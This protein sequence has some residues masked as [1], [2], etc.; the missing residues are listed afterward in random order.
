MDY[1][2]TNIAW[3]FFEKKITTISGVINYVEALKENYYQI[4]QQ[5]Y[6]DNVMY[7]EMRGLLQDVKWADEE[8]YM[9]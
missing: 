3:N 4:L 6:D 5:H 1:P 8:N 9:Q 7:L 2:D